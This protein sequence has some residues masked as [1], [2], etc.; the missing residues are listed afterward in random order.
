MGMKRY[1]INPRDE[2]GIEVRASRP[3]TFAKSQKAA[4]KAEA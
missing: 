2:I 4:L 1:V 3:T